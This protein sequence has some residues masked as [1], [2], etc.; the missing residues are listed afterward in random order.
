MESQDRARFAARR[1]QRLCASTTR[2]HADAKSGVPRTAQATVT[3]AQRVPS[4]PVISPTANN[5]TSEP[6][7]MARGGCNTTRCTEG[8][9]DAADLL[10]E[11]TRPDAVAGR[12]DDRRAGDRRR[13]RQV[14]DHEEL[15]AARHRDCD[16][17][18]RPGFR[19][20]R[21]PDPWPR[22]VHQRGIWKGRPS[23]PARL[24]MPGSPRRSQASLGGCH[25]RC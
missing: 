1:G 9:L 20:A 5:T 11:P 24:A 15:R 22:R 4:Q 17:D 18:R 25:R 12:G 14:E 23:T 21:G 6:R 7:R 19:Q 16:H 3:R 2:R 13:R 8:F 10:A